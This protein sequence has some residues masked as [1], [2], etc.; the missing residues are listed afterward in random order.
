MLGWLVKRGEAISYC[1]SLYFIIMW[2]VLLLVIKAAL[3][4]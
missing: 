1:Y 2:E 4:I 3:L